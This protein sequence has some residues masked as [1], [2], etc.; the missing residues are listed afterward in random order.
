MPDAA[1]M[2]ARPRMLLRVAHAPITAFCH[3]PVPTDCTRSD[4]RELERVAYS[5]FQAPR[6]DLA[7]RFRRS[8]VSVID[9]PEF[10]VKRT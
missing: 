4:A 6:Q 8:L 3:A 10:D 1:L 7:R 2:R 5:P 9:G